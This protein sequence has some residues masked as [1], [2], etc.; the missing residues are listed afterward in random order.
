MKHEAWREERKK[1]KVL[2]L[3]RINLPKAK[4]RWAE[5]TPGLASKARAN[6]EPSCWMELK[7]L[8]VGN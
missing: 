3:S 2:A 7:Y 5:M 8:C 6:G 1:K 4:A